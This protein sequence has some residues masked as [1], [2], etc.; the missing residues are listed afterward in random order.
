[1]QP[2]CCKKLTKKGSTFFYD[3][4]SK[5]VSL[6]N[7]NGTRCAVVA[8]WCNMDGL[9]HEEVGEAIAAMLNGTSKE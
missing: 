4:L 8:V 1:M 3:G 7:P 5:F 6:R 2:N 9:K